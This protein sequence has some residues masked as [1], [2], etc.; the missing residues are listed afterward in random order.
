MTSMQA[1]LLRDVAELMEERAREATN[2][3]PWDNTT[4]QYWVAEWLQNE[5][6]QLDDTPYKVD[7]DWIERNYRTPLGAARAYLGASNG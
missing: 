6:D 3:S 2:S 1:Q 5:A 7:S 4:F